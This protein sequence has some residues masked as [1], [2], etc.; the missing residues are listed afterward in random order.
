MRYKPEFTLNALEGRS[1]ATCGEWTRVSKA[2]EGPNV[3]N[4]D[5]MSKMASELFLAQDQQALLARFPLA[6]DEAAFYVKFLGDEYRIDRSS[7][8]VF[9]SSGSQATPQV[10]LIIMDMVCNPAG[11]PVALGEWRTVEQLSGATSSP[12]TAPLYQP[13]ID[14]FCGDVNR[15]KNACD[16]LGGQPVAGGDVSVRFELFDGF[17]LWLQFWDEDEEFPAQM[18][19]LWDKTTTLYLHYE[20][21]WY[22]M[23]EVLERLVAVR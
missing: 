11:A 10:T 21:L 18:T 15:L 17:W 2:D 7:G 9:D 23:F 6:N 3:G 1:T 12:R 14:E 16:T 13:L 8:V 4:Y 5:K 19:F 22:I 20:T